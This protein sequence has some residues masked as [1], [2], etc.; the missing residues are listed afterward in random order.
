VNILPGNELTEAFLVHFQGL[1]L[2]RAHK[3]FSFRNF[4]L[5][6]GFLTGARDL[7]SS[8]PSAI[9]LF[10]SIAGVDQGVQVIPVINSNQTVTIAAQ[11]A[12]STTLV[13]Q[14]T[15]S[16]PTSDATP[17]TSVTS[18]PTRNGK[19]HLGHGLRRDSRTFDIS[20]PLSGQPSL[21]GARPVDL[22]AGGNLGY[23]KGE[24]EKPLEAR[25]ERVFYINNYGQVSAENRIVPTIYQ[26]IFPEPNPEF[27][28][29]LS[30]RD[31]LVYSCG[32]LWTSIV[33]C[34]ALRGLAT[35]IA[36]SPSLRAKVVLRE[37]VCR[38]R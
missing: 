2:R 7:F 35:A 24:E 1:C 29:S 36:T 5:G 30:N 9:F 4:S 18:T 13:G 16:H 20:L 38:R 11:L 26:E 17:L 31:I 15:I 12:N 10:K 21:D 33:P 34:S 6:N 23:R 37:L 14:C 19:S 32:S 27:L 28:D 22:P 8:L 3:R 25:I